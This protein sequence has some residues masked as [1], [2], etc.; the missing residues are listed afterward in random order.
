MDE[1]EIDVRVE[2]NTLTLSGERKFEK[3]F[4]AERAPHGE[5]LRHVQPQLY[6]AEHAQAGRREGGVQERRADREPAEA[7][8]SEAEADQGCRKQRQVSADP[9]SGSAWKRGRAGR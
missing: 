6:P 8:G 3:E 9:A 5:V 1:K 4:S 7:R 2:K